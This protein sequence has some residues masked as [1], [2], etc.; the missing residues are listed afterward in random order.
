[1]K[2]KDYYFSLSLFRRDVNERK[3]VLTWR[4]QQQ[5]PAGLISGNGEQRTKT[6]Y[7]TITPGIGQSVPNVQTTK[8]SERRKSNVNTIDFPVMTTIRQA[9]V[10]SGLP[11]YR[12][13]ELCKSGQVRSVQCGRK[14]LVN[15]CSLAAWM[16]GSTQ[17][18]QE[19]G[20]RR[21]EL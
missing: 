20:I 2:K 9:H 10:Q 12:I 6:G 18:P 14:T 7:A 11:V 16:N 3:D 19:T 13:R 4:M 15:L 17:Q 5:K 8:Q 21:V 1:M